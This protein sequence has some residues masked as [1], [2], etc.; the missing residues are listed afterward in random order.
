[1]TATLTL[2]NRPGTVTVHDEGVVRAIA[3][4]VAYWTRTGHDTQFRV[5]RPSPSRHVRRT[6]VFRVSQVDSLNANGVDLTDLPS[7]IATAGLAVAA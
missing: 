4:T 5:R 7:P 1:M 3:A 2:H 6:L